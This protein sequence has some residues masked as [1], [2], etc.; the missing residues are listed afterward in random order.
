MSPDGHFKNPVAYLPC[1]LEHDIAYW[2]GGTEEEKEDADWEFFVC[3]LSE[4]DIAS[5][6][7]YHNAVKIGGDPRL[8]SDYRWG[9]GWKDRFDFQALTEEERALVEK[10]IPYAREINRLYTEHRM[11]CFEIKDTFERSKCLLGQEDFVLKIQE[12]FK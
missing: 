12:L 2:G 1:C 8:R 5:A 10:D 3:L 9:Y 4:A 11:S 6:A 7:V